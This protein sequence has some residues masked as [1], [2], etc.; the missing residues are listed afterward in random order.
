MS[1]KR[2]WHQH[3]LADWPSVIAWLWPWFVLKAVPWL[4]WLVSGISPRRTGCE[5]TAVHLGICGRQSVLGQVFLRVHFSPVSIIFRFISVPL[6][7]RMRNGRS[8]ETF[9][10]QRPSRRSGSFGL[11]SSFTLSLFKGLMYI[12]ALQDLGDGGYFSPSLRS[13]NNSTSY[14]GGPGLKSGLGGFFWVSLVPQ[15]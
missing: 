15:G 3:G 8:L 14:A 9:K 1:P 5:P 10:K 7:T 2:S 4:T 11:R 13:S 6:L 12:K